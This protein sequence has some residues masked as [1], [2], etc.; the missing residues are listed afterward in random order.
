MREK[1]SALMD[2]EL[3]DE[4][5][6]RTLEAIKRD[7]QLHGTWLSY[8]LIGDALRRHPGLA[9]NYAERVLERLQGEPAI[10]APGALRRQS[11]PARLATSIAASLAGIGVVAWLAFSMNDQSAA[12]AQTV[13]VAS[14]PPVAAAAVTASAALPSSAL[15]EYLFAHQGYSPSSSIQGMA[16]YMRT[17]T[18]ERQATAQ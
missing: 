18:E 12:P 16:P 2:G 7:P 6:Q 1:I 15:K 3:D 11:R 17:V 5:A 4:G 8:H 9:A 13:A 14:P 10:M